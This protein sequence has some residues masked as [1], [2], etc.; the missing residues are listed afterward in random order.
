M[1]HFLPYLHITYHIIY[2]ITISQLTL[3]KN[4]KR[5]TTINIAQANIIENFS[6]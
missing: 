6:L 3:E 4:K 1:Y 5:E 2:K